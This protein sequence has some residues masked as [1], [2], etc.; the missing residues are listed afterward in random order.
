[1]EAAVH[2]GLESLFA[3]TA[4]VALYQSDGVCLNLPVIVVPAESETYAFAGQETGAIEHDLLI[5]ASHLNVIN[6]PQR[7][8]RITLDLNGDGSTKTL[9]VAAPYGSTRLFSHHTRS[10]SV[11]RVHTVLVNEVSAT[12][13]TE[14]PST[15]TTT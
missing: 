4:V 7:G 12:T 11:L 2:S 6:G 3:Q 9:Q 14:H 10:G 13:T 5:Q 15:T 8:D 1:M